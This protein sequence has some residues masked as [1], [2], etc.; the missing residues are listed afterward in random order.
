VE[1]AT[2]QKNGAKLEKA[3]RLGNKKSKKWKEKKS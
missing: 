2:T 1:T 3:K